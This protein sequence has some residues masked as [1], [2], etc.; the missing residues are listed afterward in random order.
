MYGEISRLISTN[1]RIVA[2]GKNDT[3]IH[4]WPMEKIIGEV[5]LDSSNPEEF[6]K[7]SDKTLKLDGYPSA[8]F[9]DDV[10]NQ[11]IFLST[12]GSFWLFSLFDM[13][14]VKLKSCHDP[15]HAIKNAIDFKY[16]TPS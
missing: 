6:F 10:A 1:V 2:E 3:N 4:F 8:S 16:V 14:T 12:S 7:G 11:A 9:Y 5:K 15:S 13:G